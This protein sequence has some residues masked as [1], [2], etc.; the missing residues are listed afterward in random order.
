MNQSWLWVFGLA[1]LAQGYALYQVSRR[2]PAAPIAVPVP[3]VAV[4]APAP[5]ALAAA[6]ER[7]PAITNRHIGSAPRKPGETIWV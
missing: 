6:P 7:A 2:K 1:Q 5:A 4:I 3:Q